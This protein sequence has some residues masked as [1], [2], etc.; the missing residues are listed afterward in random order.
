MRRLTSFRKWKRG[1]LDIT[2]INTRDYRLLRTVVIKFEKMAKYNATLGT[3]ARMVE[4]YRAARAALDA[5]NNRVR[6]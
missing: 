5:F 2:T 3:N 6:P 1:V 4:L